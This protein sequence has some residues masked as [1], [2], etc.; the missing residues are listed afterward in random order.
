MVDPRRVV[1]GCPVLEVVVVSSKV[2]IYIMGLHDRQN[3]LLDL[4]R[5]AVVASRVA[6]V[7]AKN[8]LPCTRTSLGKL[9]V[10]EL[11]HP[12]SSILVVLNGDG[13]N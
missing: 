4:F 5:T 12:Q 10:Q 11:F 7:V 9:T 1:P 8:N 13:V 3:L 2:E 6:G